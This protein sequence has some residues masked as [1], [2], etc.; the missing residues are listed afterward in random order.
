[1]RAHGNEYA[2][3]MIGRTLPGNLSIGASALWT[4]LHALD[5]VDLL[6]SGSIRVK[7][8][9]HAIDVRM[10]AWKE[11]PGERGAR[12]LVEIVMLNR[13]M[14]THNGHYYV[15]DWSHVYLRI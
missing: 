2:F 15:Q 14:D 8:T 5:G 12:S 10:G 7:Q 13:I 11:W 4:G 6:Y 3:G 1:M 9:G